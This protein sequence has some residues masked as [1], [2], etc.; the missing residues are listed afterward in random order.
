MMHTELMVA[1]LVRVLTSNPANGI[2]EA[3][4]QLPRQAVKQED[5]PSHSRTWSRKTHLF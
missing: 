5:D 1:C 3:E 4:A 2:E